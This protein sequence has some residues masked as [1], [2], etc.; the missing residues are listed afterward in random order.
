[1][2]PMMEILNPFRRP[3]VVEH[4]TPFV[5]KVAIILFLIAFAI[6]AFSTGGPI[7]VAMSFAMT[8]VLF[9]YLTFQIEM[10]MRM[11]ALTKAL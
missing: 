1:M 4:A 6:L 7:N 5:T 3:F 8:V 11:I 2:D 9:V 10:I